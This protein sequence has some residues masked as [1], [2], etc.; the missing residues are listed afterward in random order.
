[1]LLNFI[2][3]KPCCFRSTEDKFKD[4]IDLIENL[5]IA[6]AHKSGWAK[7]IP[8]ESFKFAYYYGKDT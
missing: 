7:V 2:W 5:Y 8:S 6:G 3:I 4:P 1:M